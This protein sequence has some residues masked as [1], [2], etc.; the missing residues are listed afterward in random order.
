MCSK[1]PLDPC[2]PETRHSRKHTS[3]ILVQ[4]R[5]KAA[6]LEIYSH[7][8]QFS[9]TH[10][11]E[12]VQFVLEQVF[13]TRTLISDDTGSHHLFFVTIN[14]TG[15]QLSVAD[16]IKVTMLVDDEYCDLWESL[17]DFLSRWP[18]PGGS[19]L[20]THLLQCAQIARQAQLN[21]NEKKSMLTWFGEHHTQEDLKNVLLFGC[22]YQALLECDIQIFYQHRTSLGW[23]KQRL[24]KMS[25]IGNVFLDSHISDCL[26][27]NK[28]LERLEGIASANCEFHDWH[29]AALFLISTYADNVSKLKK[30]LASFTKLVI[31]FLFKKVGTGKSSTRSEFL[32]ILSSIIA[33]I[34]VKELECAGIESHIKPKRIAGWLKTLKKQE[35]SKS[36]KKGNAGGKKIAL[37]RYALA[38]YE[39]ILEDNAEPSTASIWKRIKNEGFQKTKFYTSV[40]GWLACSRM[41]TWC[42]GYRAHCSVKLGR[43]WV[44]RMGENKAHRNASHIAKFFTPHKTHS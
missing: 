30:L 14:D 21:L 20:F 18:L 3:A 9:S 7:L 10:I 35:P 16:K 11:Y 36:G 22:A 40:N 5:M 38:L 44:E 13:F 15:L 1:T 2:L 34:T 33:S 12:F 6:A 41:L 29:T 39:D 28:Q 8:Q 19:N 37:V 27:V 42:S 23:Q 31:Y 25:G 26:Q 43:S 24:L 32:A 4:E 17:E